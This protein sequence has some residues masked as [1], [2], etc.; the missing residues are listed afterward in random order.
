MK[1][2]WDMSHERKFSIR[3]SFV[4]ASRHNSCGIPWA[5]SFVWSVGIQF[6]APKDFIRKFVLDSNEKRRVQ[7]WHT[8]SDRVGVTRTLRGRPCVCILNSWNR[9]QR[10]Q[11]A[12]G[13]GNATERPFCSD[14]PSEFGAR[15][16]MERVWGGPGQE[17]RNKG[18]DHA[19]RRRRRRR[20]TT[21]SPGAEA[22]KSRPAI[23]RWDG[24]MRKR[25]V[26]LA[27]P[28]PSPALAD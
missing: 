7:K 11:G 16:V 27:L 18:S 28:L 9:P 22:G 1:I 13:M 20:G 24:T 17:A 15:R 19:N 26:M 6:F 14:L 23:L 2:Q 5:R 4:A 21:S 10:E 3:L 12:Y 8:K 25:S